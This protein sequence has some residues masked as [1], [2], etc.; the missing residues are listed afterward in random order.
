MSS[1]LVL[2]SVV[3][4]AATGW[5]IAIV[6]VVPDIIVQL[7]IMRPRRVYRAVRHRFGPSLGGIRADSSER[8]NYESTGEKLRHVE[9]LLASPFANEFDVRQFR[10]LRAIRS[11][12]RVRAPREICW[13]NRTIWFCGVTVE[14][15]DNGKGRS[16]IRE[17]ILHAHPTSSTAPAGAAMWWPPLFSRPLRRSERHPHSKHKQSQAQPPG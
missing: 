3:I 14:T 11:R 4:A 17:S 2:H 9:I 15:S 1:G 6:V 8:E 13:L 5:Q 16:R 7:P 10:S 12:H